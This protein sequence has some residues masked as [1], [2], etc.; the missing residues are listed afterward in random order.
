MFWLIQEK[1]DF[2]FFQ[3]EYNRISDTHQ[4][5]YNRISDTATLTDITPFFQLAVLSHH[6]FEQT[7]LLILRIESIIEF[8]SLGKFVLS[9]HLSYITFIFL[10]IFSQ[11][12]KNITFIFSIIFSN[13]AFTLSLFFSHSFL[14]ILSITIILISS[15]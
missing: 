1:N 7:L 3:P 15:L 10:V 12:L 8:K 11:H 2:N 4:P 5:E 14:S 13:F 6:F 9:Q